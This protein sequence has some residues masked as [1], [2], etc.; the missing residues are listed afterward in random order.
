MASSA[1]SLDFHQLALQSTCRICGSVFSLRRPR[2]HVCSGLAA[3]L[4]GAFGV[5]VSRD[6]ADRAI[7]HNCRNVVARWEAAK[8]ERKPFRS[9]QK[10]LEWPDH[11]EEDCSV[12]TAFQKKSRGG[13]TVS[14]AKRL[15]VFAIEIPSIML[16]SI[17]IGL[18]TRSTQINQC[19]CT[20]G[21]ST[22]PCSSDRLQSGRPAE[23]LSGIR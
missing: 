11:T 10:P 13:K 8:K 12:C 23:A 18:W 20:R 9:L 19:G 14:A 22:A 17:C 4:Q 1:S 5:D 7:C 6:E 3:Q 15:K 2:K 21:S 16:M